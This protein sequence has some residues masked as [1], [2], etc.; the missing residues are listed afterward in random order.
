MGGS[1]KRVADDLFEVVV[2][3]V[4]FFDI[5]VQPRVRCIVRCVDCP[6]SPRIFRC[7]SRTDEI[8][9]C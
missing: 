8:L 9:A 3:P 5:W 1:L 2:S 7:L 4:Q 6:L